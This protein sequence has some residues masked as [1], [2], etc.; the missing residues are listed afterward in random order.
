MSTRIE[1]VDPVQYAEPASRILQ[2]AWKPPCLY[3]SADY[4]AWQFGF[5]SHLPRLAAIAFLD[6]RAVGCIAVTAR[7]LASIHGTFA[8]YVLSF[9]AV[10]P[11]ATRRGLAAGMYASLVQVLPSDIPIVA[12]TEPASVGERLLLDSLR[13][14][15]RHRAFAPCR[16]VG[17]LARSNTRA[18][19]VT[20]QEAPTYEEFASA[21]RR[22]RDDKAL[23][24]DVAAEHWDHYA[25]DPRGRAMVTIR[26]EQRSPV[27]TAMIVSAEIVSAQGVQRVPMLESVALASATPSALAALFEF[28]AGRVQPGVTVIA[29][30]LSGID[31]TLVRAA[32][33]RI[34]PSSF[35]AHA[36]VRGKPHIVE[37][38]E[39]LNLEVI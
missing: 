35:N 17:F 16:A 9:V 11:T 27:G 12:F 25:Q 22:P 34:L 24:T 31:A 3:Y 28:A 29:S 38:A 18:A 10:D 13:G 26:D 19:G 8:A 39:T 5:P 20:V 30:N 15:F 4:L 14:T 33:A 6:D 36:F 23:T 21:N 32:G 7:Y 2:A 37:Q 1:I